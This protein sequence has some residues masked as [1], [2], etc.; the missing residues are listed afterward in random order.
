MTI[1]LEKMLEFV[2]GVTEEI[3][4]YKDVGIFFVREWMVIGL[5]GGVFVAV[6]FG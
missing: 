1:V 4:L 6:V 2:D 5:K 3:I